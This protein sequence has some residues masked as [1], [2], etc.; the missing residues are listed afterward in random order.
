MSCWREKT[1]QIAERQE[2]NQKNQTLSQVPM[3]PSGATCGAISV[4]WR[5]KLVH[6]V[7]AVSFFGAFSVEA[8]TADT[9]GKPQ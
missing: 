8:G 1:N 4:R 5:C 7:R 6:W 9:H 3:T 2:K